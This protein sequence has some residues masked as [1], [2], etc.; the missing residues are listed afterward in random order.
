MWINFIKYKIRKDKVIVKLAGVYQIINTENKKIYIGESEDIAKRWTDHITQLVNGS[1]YNLK[2]Q[3]DFNKYGISNFKF[4]VLELIQSDKK[5]KYDNFY[6]LKIKLLA[7]EHFYIKKYNTIDDGYNIEDSLI[8]VIINNKNILKRDEEA[9]N[10][11]KFLIKQ[12]LKNDSSLLTEDYMNSNNINN[13]T[14]KKSKKDYTNRIIYIS[15]LYRK[16]LQDKVIPKNIDL[17]QYRDILVD[18]Q[19]LEYKNHSYYIT[20]YSIDKDILNI[21]AEYKNKYGN[22]CNK[23]KVTN[24]GIKIITDIMTN[25]F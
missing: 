18:N 2:L 1:H 13:K 23:L 24:N 16:L 7:R 21:G 14:S 12:V 5:T 15:T 10:F 22:I 9:P 3:N 19:I 8:N 25:K 17:N 6:V 20:Q 11:Q 4:D